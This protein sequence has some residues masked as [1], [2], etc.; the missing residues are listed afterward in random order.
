MISSCQSNMVISARLSD[1]SLFKSK[2]EGY[3]APGSITVQSVKCP[4]MGV[5]DVLVRRENR[6]NPCRILYV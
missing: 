2:T 1:V 4:L 3:E 6:F 5:L